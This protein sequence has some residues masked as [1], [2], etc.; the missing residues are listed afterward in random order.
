MWLELTLSLE[1]GGNVTFEGA[2]LLSHLLSLKG[3][4]VR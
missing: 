2:L 4:F 3:R 1:N